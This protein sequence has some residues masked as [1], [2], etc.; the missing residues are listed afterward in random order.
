MSNMLP[1]KAERVWLVDT[2]GT[3]IEKKAAPKSLTSGQRHYMYRL[4]LMAVD[5]FLKQRGFRS[6]TDESSVAFSYEKSGCWIDVKLTAPGNIAY[7]T[8]YPGYEYKQEGIGKAADGQER[9]GVRA[10]VVTAKDIMG[11]DLL[12]Q[13]MLST[14]DNEGTRKPIFIPLPKDLSNPAQHV[15]KNV[16]GTIAMACEHIPKMKSAFTEAEVVAAQETAIDV[17]TV[18]LLP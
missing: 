1:V 14:N 9:Y 11:S 2:T 6:N 8:S 13:V 15:L 4:G 12:V 7:V 10:K 5:Q 16:L 3:A 18:P 17:S